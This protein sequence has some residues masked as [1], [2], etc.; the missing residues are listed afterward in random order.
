MNMKNILLKI[1]YDGTNFHGWQKQP[2][3]RTVQGELENAL[4]IVCGEEIKINGT[5][6]TDA[7]VHAKGQMANFKADIKIP[8]DR[9]KIAVNNILSG[10]KNG[11]SVSG[12]VKIL[13]VTEKDVDFHARFDA[14]G[15][16]Y[17]YK[18]INSAEA[19][20][21]K[22]NYYYQIEK[23]L[24]FNLMQEAAIHI[25]GTKDFK[26]FQAAGGE[27]KQTTVRTIHSLKI[28][29]AE[30]KGIDIEVIGD[31]FLYNM[32]RIIAGTLVDIG[33]GKISPDSMPYIIESC[34]RQN[35][36]HTAPPQGLYLAEVYYM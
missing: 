34:D 15:K 18:I 31:G 6:R 3:K 22:R 21:F 7:G 10:G 25:V 9:I 13:D 20:I 16:K 32:V 2:D 5:S 35:A 28:I 8:T 36:G 11:M 12:D 17:I 1:E 26:S 23:P 27:E 14:K 4:S 33:L 29:N 24:A 19:D 30:E